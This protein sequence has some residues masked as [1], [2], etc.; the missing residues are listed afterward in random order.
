M[1]YEYSSCTIVFISIV[2]VV[3]TDTDA[4]LII[5]V[6]LLLII[7]LFSVHLGTRPLHQFIQREMCE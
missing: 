4:M 5:S 3:T 6:L 1:A 2:A 7:Y